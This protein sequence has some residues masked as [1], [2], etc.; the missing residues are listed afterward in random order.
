MRIMARLQ[1]C[2]GGLFGRVL[3]VTIWFLS[4]AGCDEPNIQDAV[5]DASLS[6]VPSPTRTTPQSAEDNPDNV[7][8]SQPFP[9]ATHGG[10]E[11]DQGTREDHAGTSSLPTTNANSPPN[12]AAAVPVN[13]ALIASAGIRKLTG[14]HV[15]IYTDLAASPAVDELP[16]VFDQAVPQWAEYFSIPHDKT[17]A[18]PWHVVGHLI[19]DKQK[20]LSTGLLPRDLPP[21]LHG[22]QRGHQIWIYEQPSE[23]YRRH[24]LVHEGTH[25]FMRQFLGSTGPPWYMEGLAELLGT[26]RWADNQL[27]I[28]HTPRHR[29][30]VPYWGRVKIVRDLVEQNQAKMLGP[31]MDQAAG[32]FLRVDAYGWSWAAATFLDRHPRYRERFRALHAQVG[33]PQFSQIV[34]DEFA[35]D[36]GEL[37]EE[38]QL[39]VLNLDYGY[40]LAREAV[41]FAAAT[42][43]QQLT[44]PLTIRADRGWQSTGLQLKA[45]VEYT[46][47][48]AG[49]FVVEDEPEPWWC[50]PNGVTIRYHQGRPLGILLYAIRPEPAQSGLTAL[51]QPGEIGVGRII[52]PKQTGTLF[53][54]INDSPA[55]LADNTG[56]LT[57]HVKE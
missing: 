38:W 20:F 10:T 48:A 35:E 54:R 11:L 53:L 8:R 13:E 43:P 41:V 26:H 31:I 50:E 7:T 29:D 21:F 14:R 36:W 25:A 40:D 39:F 22:Y 2:N 1:F 19:S 45:D 37:T 32:E 44:D 46:I 56:S 6:S 47:S 17:S 28:A 9:P 55:E 51:A 24:L 3:L 5:S 23:Y 34:R 42:P 12:P 15:V 52:T 27:T 30:E 18:D 57:V 16:Q 33:E 4:I 49:R